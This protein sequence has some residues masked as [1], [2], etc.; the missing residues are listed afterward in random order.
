MAAGAVAIALSSASEDEYS[1]WK[2]AAQREIALYNINPHYVTTR[3][4]GHE[5]S[6]QEARRTWFDWLV[7]A[8]ATLIFVGLGMMAHI[9]Q[10]LIHMGW[11]LALSAAML[12]VLIAAGIALWRVTRFT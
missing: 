8:V 11:L 2:E 9:P 12:V 7:I 5:L 3:M 6:P 4:E 10:M 1:Q